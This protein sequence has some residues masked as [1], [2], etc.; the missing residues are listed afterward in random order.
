MNAQDL[1][2][3]NY[4][5][6]TNKQTKEKL[7]IEV[8][9]SCIMDI[10]SNGENSS[11]IYEPI[12]LTKEWLLKMPQFKKS[13]YFDYKFEYKKGEDYSEGQMF[14]EVDFNTREIQFSI[15]VGGDNSN[16]VYLPM[17]E[18]LHIFQNLYF[19]LTNE[20]LTIKN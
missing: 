10:H 17:P 1:R 6:R 19:A 18:F 20:E 12:P 9:P 7:L 15:C 14:I 11:F 4:V 3:G 5:Y 8:T 13:Q 16:W 2:I